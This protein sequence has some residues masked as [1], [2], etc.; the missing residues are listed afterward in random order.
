MLL[1]RVYCKSGVH[2]APT[3][4]LSLVGALMLYSPTVT[5]ADVFPMSLVGNAASSA[6]RTP[7]NWQPEALR[8]Q[9]FLMSGHPFRIDCRQL[10]ASTCHEVVVS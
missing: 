8:L 1:P 3:V 7:R 5:L 6:Y 4:A 9:A 10:I 2:R